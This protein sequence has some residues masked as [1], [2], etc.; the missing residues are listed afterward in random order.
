[1]RRI[2]LVLLCILAIAGTIYR[3]NPLVTQAQD[4][5]AQVAAAAAAAAATYVTLR[6][7]NAFLSTA[8]E[9]E[10]GVSF[11]ASGTAQ[12]LKVLE[13]VD[14][15]VERV[16][17]IV[18]A[19]MVV[20]GVIAV[21]LG[22]VSALGFGVM[23]LALAVHIT[24]GP[25]GGRLPWRMACYGGFLGLVLPAALV[26]AQP[27]AI[28]MTEATYLENLALVQ[29]ITSGIGSS[30]A[31]ESD[32]PGLRE[33]RDLASNLWNRADELISGLLVIVGVHIFRLLVLPLLVVAG[34]FVTM[35][36]FA[37]GQDTLG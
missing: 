27:L 17:S 24:L 30:D 4:Y 2:V 26:L 16:A 14:D 19:V 33:Y 35:R 31:L 18:F 3:D 13:P 10:V 32:E 22:P 11:I 29:D 28:G 15:T 37:R 6:T 21:S 1:M 12:P 36:H 34:L 8:Q 7:L 5:A 25:R 9:L 20:T 23:A